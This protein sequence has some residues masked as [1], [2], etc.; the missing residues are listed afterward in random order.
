METKWNKYFKTQTNRRSLPFPYPLEGT[1]Y[2]LTPKKEHDFKVLC[3]AEWNMHRYST[4]SNWRMYLACL[5]SHAEIARIVWFCCFPYPSTKFQTF[6]SL[7]SVP[8]KFSTFSKLFLLW[9][10]C[11]KVRHHRFTLVIVICLKDEI[12]VWKTEVFQGEIQ[13]LHSNCRWII[14]NIYKKYY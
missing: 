10:R 9:G 2:F 4:L 11:L 5:G 13:Y 7:H 14:S 3:W 8:L 6:P 12:Y 1:N